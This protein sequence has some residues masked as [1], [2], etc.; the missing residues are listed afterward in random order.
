MHM[1]LKS[2]VLML[3]LVPIALFALV[4]SGAI[5]KVL[6]SQAENE[7]RE[8]RERLLQESRSELEHY[9]Q[10]ALGSVQALYD[11]A[12]SGDTASRAQAIAILSKI[13][14]GKDGY[15]FG[16]DSEIVRLFRGDSPEGVGVSFKDRRDPPWVP[17]SER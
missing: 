13:K 9:M 10:I 4:L 11:A 16:Y 8:T 5:A 3:A 1:T 14:Y 12:P 7:L 6:H 15:L 2:K 17:T